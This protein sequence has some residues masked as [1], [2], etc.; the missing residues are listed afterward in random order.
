MVVGLELSNVLM[1]FPTFIPFAS[2]VFPRMRLLCC[3]HFFKVAK[4]NPGKQTCCKISQAT[5]DVTSPSIIKRDVILH[6]IDATLL[7]ASDHLI[8]SAC[9]AV[10]GDKCWFRIVYRYRVEMIDI[11]RWYRFLIG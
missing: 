7:H 1:D 11:D 6:D 3:F 9:Q 5:S 10:S 4:T 2:M 8:S